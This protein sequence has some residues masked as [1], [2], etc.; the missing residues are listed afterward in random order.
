MS[1]CNDLI[2]VCEEAH[3]ATGKDYNDIVP[4]ALTF[5]KYNIETLKQLQGVIKRH[6]AMTEAER[7]RALTPF[8]HIVRWIHNVTN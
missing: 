8:E 4:V 6:D 7:L 5:Q 3:T 1:L 2:A